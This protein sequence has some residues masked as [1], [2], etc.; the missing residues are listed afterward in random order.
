MNRDI[1]TEDEYHNLASVLTE[2]HRWQGAAV[3]ARHAIRLCL[4][5]SA[6][7]TVAQPT[8]SGHAAPSSNAV[9]LLP[10]CYNQLGLALAGQARYRA[11]Q[12]AYHA[13]RKVNP[14]YAEPHSN[15]GNL[16]QEQGRLPEAL[17][18]YELALV[19]EP[20]SASS[21]WNRAL[22]LLQSGDYARGWP[23]YEWRWQR[24]QTPPRPFRQPRWDGSPLA[25]RT[26]L[27]YMEQGLGDM[28]MF[29]RY[30]RLAKA[31]GGRVMVECPPEMVD[32]FGRCPGID[33]VVAEGT[34]LPPFDV[35]VPLMSLPG[36]L[37]TTLET[38][39][40]QVP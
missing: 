3:W 35:Q 20:Q 32:L 19:Y 33:S 6:G 9:S 26:L 7:G 36:L 24:P 1:R 23:E 5:R 34:L 4:K 22:S 14:A 13:A 28:L 31:R 10:S 21:H 30:A 38:V 37:E 15:L 11:A 29:I 2:L 25:R 27:I 17:A 12:R 18:A 16:Y 39:P 8:A 40:R